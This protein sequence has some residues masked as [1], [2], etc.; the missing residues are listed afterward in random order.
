MSALPLRTYRGR[1]VRILCDIVREADSPRITTPIRDSACVVEV[2]RMLQRMGRA[3]VEREA[4]V[5]LLLN[6]RHVPLG[7][8]VASVGT[9]QSAPV[10]PRE[11]FRPAVVAGAAAIIVMHNHPSGDATP[12]P[13][14]HAV[15]QRLRTVGDVVGI[16]LLDQ[17]VVV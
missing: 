7:V 13:E 1:G 8:H 16:E 12:S 11:V 17:I 9:L 6:S 3:P 4:F 14:D 15:T 2:L 10:H 5:V